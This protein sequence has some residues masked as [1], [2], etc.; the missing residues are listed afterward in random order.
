ML[1]IVF[2]PALALAQ[3]PSQSIAST[4]AK[5][6]WVLN[7][8]PMACILSRARAG[9]EGGFRMETR[10]F[11]VDHKFS[12]LLPKINKG[13]FVKVGR[14]SVPDPRLGY[15]P[16]IAVEEKSSEPDRIVTSSISE[17]QLAD[18]TKQMTLGITIPGKLNER[19]SVVGLAKA[20]LALDQCEKDLAQRWGTPQVWAVDPKPLAGPMGLIQN[21][22]YPDSLVRAN[23]EG[24]ARLMV[25]IDPDGQIQRCRVLESIGPI[26]FAEVICGVYKKRLR[27][28]PATDAAGAKVSSYYTMPEVRFVLAN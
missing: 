6:K 15:P 20:L 4:K 26:T 11:E 2:L 19:V 13:S 9:T 28:T 21:G 8:A 22:D 7:Y 25:Q 3:L 1:S 16:V 5:P 17:V 23:I 24:S 14:L 10:P 12:L 27:F 18:L